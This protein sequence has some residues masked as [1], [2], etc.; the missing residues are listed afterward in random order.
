MAEYSNNNVIR[1]AYEYNN[2][3]F[4][5][6]NTPRI[7]AG[8]GSTTGKAFFEGIKS[9]GARSVSPAT[10]FKLPASILIFLRFM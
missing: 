7:D 6:Q 10:C 4:L 1:G 9:G 3:C 8:M 5:Q 2:G